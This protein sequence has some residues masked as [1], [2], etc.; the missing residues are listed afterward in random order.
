MKKTQLVLASAVAAASLWA[1]QPAAAQSIL[2]PSTPEKGVWMEAARPNFK[3]FDTTLPSTVWYVSGRLPVH[4]RLRAVVDVPFVYAQFKGD[5]E[6]L[7]T[8][9]SSVI[10]N[11]FLGLDYVASKQLLLEL[12][13][14][15][16]LTTANENSF[17]DLIGFLADPQRAEAFLE[18]VVPVS[19]AVTYEQS[20]PAGLGL[21]ARGGATT[22]FYTGAEEEQ[23]T[24]TLV[25]YGLFGS[26]TAGIA[27]LGA[28]VSGRWAATADEGSFSE[29][30][31]HQV[32]F[33]ADA[34]VRGVRPGVSLRIPVDNN[35]DEVL[36]Y[37]IGVYLQVPLR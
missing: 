26:Y 29:K 27:R 31:L 4:E 24:E 17:A 14:R 3:M 28:G 16:P 13:F 8:E 12:G 7:G 5:E 23:G 9:S 15:A 34:L 36:G 37:S 2:M 11:P 19:G 25:D 35:Y 10:G 33:T 21:R 22:L 18:D 1:A 32:G 30:S 20:L 6:L